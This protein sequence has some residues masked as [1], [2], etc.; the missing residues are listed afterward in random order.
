MNLELPANENQDNLNTKQSET[1][2]FSPIYKKEVESLPILIP[3]MGFFCVCLGAMFLHIQI[4][5]FCFMPQL[6]QC[7]NDF[8]LLYTFLAQFA[9][10][11]NGIILLGY[12]CGDYTNRGFYG[13]RK[14]KIICYGIG[15]VGSLFFYL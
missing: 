14:F 8:S 12:Y 10:L 1:P 15:V 6:C 9:Q 5:D 4:N 13:L 11:Y 2:S 3:I 7:K